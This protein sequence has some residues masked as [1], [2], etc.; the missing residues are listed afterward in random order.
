M[1]HLFL[2][3]LTG[4]APD[5]GLGFR[6]VDKPVSPRTRQPLPPVGGVVVKVHDEACWRRTN[7]FQPLGAPRV[8]QA[9]CKCPVLPEGVC[10]A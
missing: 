10:V 2:Q 6:G 3:R 5:K 8:S 9:N 7:D 1:N 4:D